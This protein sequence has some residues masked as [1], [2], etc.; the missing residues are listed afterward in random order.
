MSFTTGVL[1]DSEKVSDI[2]DST[3]IPII[4]SKKSRFSNINIKNRNKRKKNNQ[5]TRRNNK[6]TSQL[7]VYFYYNKNCLRI[8]KTYIYLCRAN[9]TEEKR[10]NKVMN[11]V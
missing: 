4:I 7:C 2:N 6:N 3:V 10:L 9:L 8:P 5:K 1:L 11:L